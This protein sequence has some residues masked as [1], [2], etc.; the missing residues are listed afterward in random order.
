MKL[1]DRYLLGQFLAWFLGSLFALVMLAVLFDLFERLDVFVDYRTP[2]PVIARFYGYGLTTI[3]AQIL[4]YA[5]LLGAVLSLGQLHRHNELTAM[6][7]SGQSPWRL[8]RP[9]VI[10]ALLLCAMQYVVNEGFAPYHYVENKRILM[11]EIK[12]ISAADPE[13]QTHV[14]LIGSGGRFWFAQFYDAKGASLRRVTLQTL[15]PPTLSR[16]I[17]AERAQYEAGGVWRFEDGYLRI[18]RDSTETSIRFQEYA[19]SALTEEPRD[20]AR[21]N[22]D[23]F[24]SGMREL[25]RFARRVRESGGET[26]KHMT[27]FHLRASYPLSGLIMVLL[28]AGLGMRVIRGG[29]IA[30]GIGISLAVGFAYFALIRF[31]QAL[32][33]NGTLPPAV[34]A[35]IGNVVFL[36]LAAFIF[37]R[38]AH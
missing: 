28:G 11:E 16:R 26:Q 20:F 7:A 36:G 13:S 8:A 37:R 5:M 9:L 6:Q 23:P 33:Y 31:G 14:R 29:N 32:G 10:V 38:L 1:L 3:L 4:P 15:D 2:L 12:K 35:W 25:L 22:L 27:N 18:F 19:T 21:R 30:V 24:H 34:A 17:D